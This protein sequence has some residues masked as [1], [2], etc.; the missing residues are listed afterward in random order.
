MTRVRIADVARAAGVSVTT[1]SLVLNDR[2]AARFPETTRTRIR[3]LAR[4]MGYEPNVLARGLRTRRTHTIGLLSDRIATTPF[5]VG[6]VEAAQDVAREHGRLLFLVGTGG[7]REVEE[8]A[9]RAL[10]AQ[11]VDGMIYASMWHRPVDPPADLPPGTVFLDCYPVGDDARPA[12]V[13]D[14]L[15]G[16]R[17]AIAHLV[18]AG[19]RRIGLVDIDEDPRP[20]AS[21]LRE[22]GYREVLAEAGVAPDPRWHVRSAT[23]A[24]ADAAAAT[25][26][27]LALPP[28]DRPTAV[29]C[30]ND[31]VA[32]GA[33]TAARRHGL[34]IPQDL[35]VVGYDDL[36][37]IAPELDPPLTTVALPH[38]AMGRWATEVLLGVRPPPDE[39]DGVLRMPCPLVERGSVSPP[40]VVP[41]QRTGDGQ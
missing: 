34:R 1:V 4:E 21:V 16:A 6:M 5:A 7:V 8:D 20:V 13:P 22:Q 31:Q 40:P 36:V 37:L 10:L 2:N 38:H 9:V 12:V 3:D 24:A 39:A 11:Q 25:E 33:Y 18:A 29:F 19:H 35:S 32:H 15:G 17:A 41:G 23:T 30:Y 28:A 27:L 26:T 14:D